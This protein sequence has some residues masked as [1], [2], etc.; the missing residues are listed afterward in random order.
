MSF[1]RL[2]CTRSP[3]FFRFL[4]QA[5]DTYNIYSIYSLFLHRDFLTL[6][7]SCGT[8]SWYLLKIVRFGGRIVKK[9]NPVALLPI[10]VF[11]VIYL[12]LGLTFEYGLHIPMGF[13][14]V[15]IIIAFLAA[16]LVARHLL[17]Q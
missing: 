3:L 5:Q 9:G 8:F 15:P 4:H 2:P 12:G 14:N 1:S 7:L 6:H 10:G 16:I 17:S 13:Y 11:L